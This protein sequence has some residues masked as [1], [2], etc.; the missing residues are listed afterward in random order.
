MFSTRVPLAALV[1]AASLS[2]A[3]C[4]GGSSSDEADGRVTALAAKSQGASD[5]KLVMKVLSS[6]PEYVTGGDA[7]IQVTA[8]PGLH[9]KLVFWLNG[10]QIAPTMTS[11]GDKLEGVVTGLVLGDNRLEVRHR[12]GQGLGV[13][14]A[15]QLVNH[16]SPGRCSP[17]RTWRR[18]NAAR[19]NRTSARRSMP[20]ARSPRATTTS[21]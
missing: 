20:T 14:G 18:S 16:R 6:R 19:C 17:A 1:A 21:T 8:D 7:R 4:G 12:N 10:T 13:S 9:D 5:G 2:L 11:S 15:I 3:A